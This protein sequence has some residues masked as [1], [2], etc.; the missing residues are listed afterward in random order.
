MLIHLASRCV[1][2]PHPDGLAAEEGGDVMDL[3]GAIAEFVEDRT[4]PIFG[5]ANAQGFADALPGWH[6]AEM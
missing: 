3:D 2:S 1:A 5:I 4:V 6:D